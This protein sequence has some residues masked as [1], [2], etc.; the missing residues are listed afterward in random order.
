MA[1]TEARAVGRAGARPHRRVPGRARELVSMWGH[2]DQEEGPRAFAEKREPQLATAGRASRRLTEVGIGTAIVAYIEP[3][4][5]QAREF[6]RWYERDHLY[7]ATTAGP[8]AFAGARWVAT[9]WC[10]AVRPAGR[11]LVRRSGAR[12]FLTTVLAARRHAGANGT[13][14]LRARWRTCGAQP[15]A[16]SPGAITCI[17]RCTD[18]LRSARRRRRRRPRPR[19][20]TVRRRDRDR[21]PRRRRGAERCARRSSA[22]SARRRRCSRP[23]ACSSSQAEPPPHDLVLGFTPGDPFERGTRGRARARV[24]SDV[25]FASPFLRTIPGTDTYI[26]DL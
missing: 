24:A 1:A 10:K 20:T 26:D 18:S 9:A 11:D 25:G 15:T 23:S 13:R 6:N 16:C 22:P 17:P 14:G 19:S 8:G 4:E 3:H 21:G 5:G 2:P 7:A 12:S